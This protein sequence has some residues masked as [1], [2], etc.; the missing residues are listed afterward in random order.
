MNIPK[1]IIEKAIA[2]GWDDYKTIRGCVVSPDEEPMLAALDPTFWQALG[3]SLGWGMELGDR[4]NGAW[5]YTAL[6]FYEL[7]LEG[8][9]TTEFWEEMLK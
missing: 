5:K 3:K 1:E 2:G 9:D 4:D 8:K 7:I 6:H